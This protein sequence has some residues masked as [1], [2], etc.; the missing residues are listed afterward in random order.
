[1]TLLFWKKNKLQSLDQDEEYVWNI[2]KYCDEDICTNDILELIHETNPDYKR[3]MLVTNLQ[4]LSE[5]KYIKTYRKGRIA[6]VH[7]HVKS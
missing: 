3:T 4:K 2:L 5:K 6:Y 7:I 1:M